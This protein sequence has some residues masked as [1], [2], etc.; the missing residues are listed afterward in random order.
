MDHASTDGTRGIARALSAHVVHEPER[1]I[2]RARNAGAA[3][4]R[5]R[6]L[7]FV[8]ADTRPSAELLRASLS[9]LH[10]GAVCGGGAQVAFETLDRI[11]Y[12]WG[13]IFW[14]AIALRLNLAAGCL[15]VRNPGSLRGDR[16]FQRAGVRG[17]RDPVLPADAP[18]G[19]T[20]RPAVSR[21]ARTPGPDLCT[22]GGVVLA[23]AAPRA[24]GAAHTVPRRTALP[25]TVRVLVPP[26]RRR[27]K[28]RAH[29]MTSIAA[30]GCVA[31]KTSRV[32]A[33]NE[34]RVLVAPRGRTGCAHAESPG[35]FPKDCP[36]SG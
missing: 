32:L 22:Q 18:L 26:P 25:A 1:R 19:P 6:F 10:S 13:T 23:V 34:E 30:G 28:K 27:V 24:A 8:D 9:R 31:G 4:L 7:I 20:A 36:R 33:L 16:R 12:R 11:L 5:G 3:A 29:P 15:R 21:A 17:R 14:N 35:W 2:A